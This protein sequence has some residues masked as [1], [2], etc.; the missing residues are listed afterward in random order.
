[1]KQSEWIS[2]AAKQNIG[3]GKGRAQGKVGPRFRR[4]TLTSE[5]KQR[6]ELSELKSTAPA[7]HCWGMPSQVM[8]S[9]RSRFSLTQLLAELGGPRI[10]GGRLCIRAIACGLHQTQ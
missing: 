9:F 8:V 7:I 1:M 3:I 4:E 2:E 10:R 5:P 6:A